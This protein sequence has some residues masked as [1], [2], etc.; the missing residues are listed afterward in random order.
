MVVVSELCDGQPVCPVCLHMVNVQMKILFQFLIDS[1]S[2]SI[3]LEVI[4]SGQGCLHSKQL[5]QSM[6]ELSH[7]LSSSVRDYFLSP[8]MVLPHVILEKSRRSLSGNC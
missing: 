6:G 8:S 2:L 7:E 4:S 5:V 3:N 1:L